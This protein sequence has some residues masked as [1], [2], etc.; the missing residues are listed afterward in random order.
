MNKRKFLRHLR[1]QMA[2][3]QNLLKGPCLT[4]SYIGAR[5]AEIDLLE[6]LIR[7]TKKGRFDQVAP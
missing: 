5:E 2:C 4:G 1:K 7:D 3:M 6:E